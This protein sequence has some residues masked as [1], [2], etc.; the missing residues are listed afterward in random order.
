MR[1]RATSKRPITRM[2]PSRLRTASIGP[3][4][5]PGIRWTRRS[6][7]TGD[8]APGSNTIGAG[9]R[10]IPV[11]LVPFSC[12]VDRSAL[13]CGG[14]M[15]QGILRAVSVLHDGFLPGWNVRV[16]RTLRSDRTSTIRDSRGFTRS[17]AGYRRYHTRQIARRAGCSPETG[18]PVVR[19]WSTGTI[20]PAPRRVGRDDTILA[21][22]G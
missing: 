5:V 1:E 4:C 10:S 19:G 7:S 15:G 12:L 18:W 20:R 17:S 3:T 22:R 9:M 13:R 8:E 21:S 6:V 14:V 2:G 16:F 11:S